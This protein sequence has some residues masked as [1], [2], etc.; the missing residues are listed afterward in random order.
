MRGIV[1]AG[2]RKRS[3]KDMVYSSLEQDW[4]HSVL[5]FG[6]NSANISTCHV[7]N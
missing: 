5:G 6:D 7:K 2:K 4:G 1:A 3:L